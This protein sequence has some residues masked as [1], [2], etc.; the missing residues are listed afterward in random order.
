MQRKF[1]VWGGLVGASRRWA[2]S[3]PCSPRPSPGP[4]GLGTA[5]R[6]LSAL[7][8]AFVS[9]SADH[10]AQGGDR[11]VLVGLGWSKGLSREY[12]DAEGLARL[13]LLGSSAQV[14]FGDLKAGEQWDV[15]LVENRPGGS[16]LPEP[17]DRMQRLGRVTAGPE[18]VPAGRPPRVRLLQSLPGGHGGGLAGRHAAGAGGRPLR[19]SRAV[20][21]AVYPGTAEA[22]R[23]GAQPT[24][25]SCLRCSA[26]SR[27]SR[28][29]STRSTR[30]SPRA[31]TSSSTRSSTATAGPV[32]PA[33]R[34]TTTSRSI[35]STS[36][37]CRRTIRCSWPRP[38]PTWRRTSR[39]RN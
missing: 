24:R 36:R 8:S 12:S 29:R 13:D 27:P 1:K 22:A 38:T 28:R 15:W 32:A 21:E 37:P 7:R 3:R 16:A 9:W 17:S 34:R 30:W 18:G 11:N 20:P 39:S 10:S 19:R 25:R 6:N 31:P 35:P 2:C 26:P 5:R 23:P 14:A 33:T 4:P